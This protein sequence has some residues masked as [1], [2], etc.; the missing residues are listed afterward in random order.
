MIFCDFGYQNGRQ[1]PGPCFW[2]SKMPE[3]SG[4]MCLNHIK[5]V[6]F[7]WFHLCHWFINFTSGGKVLGVILESGGGLGDTFFDFWGSWKQ[8]GILMYFGIPPGSPKAESTEKWKVKRESWGPGEHT[9]SKNT[10]PLLLIWDYTIPLL[11]IWEYTS[12]HD[13]IT[14]QI[15]LIPWYKN[16]WLATWLLSLV[17]PDKQGPADIHIWIYV[18]LYTHTYLH[19]CIY[20]YI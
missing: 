15:D 13:L 5:T 11:L 18:H 7:E 12:T 14:V 3:C 10:V 17:A 20:A 6:V 4:C 8:V 9:K 1:F 19:K 16:T 2:W